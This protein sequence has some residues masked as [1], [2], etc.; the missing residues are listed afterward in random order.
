[1]IASVRKA[2]PYGLRQFSIG[3]DGIRIGNRLLDKEGLLGGKPTRR[4]P[5]EALV[6]TVHSPDD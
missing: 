4:R 5:T 2:V 3:D 6:A 1:M